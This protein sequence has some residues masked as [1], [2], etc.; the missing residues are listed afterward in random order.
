MA[1][2]VKRR[3][4]WVDDD[5]LFYGAFFDAVSEKFDVTLVRD[6]DQFWSAVRAQGSKAFSGI[7][8]DV[9]LP[10]GKFISSAESGGGMQTGMALLRQIRMNSATKKV[11]VLIFTIRASQDVAQ[12]GNELGATVLRK[13]EVDLEDLVRVTEEMF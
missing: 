9:L 2:P 1:A 3:I 4:I 6:P 11:P 13:Q 10:Y 8:L 12:T 5:I 7:I